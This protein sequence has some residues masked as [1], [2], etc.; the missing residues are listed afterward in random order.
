MSKTYLSIL[1]R[2]PEISL[3]EL[4]AQ[5]SHVQ[6]ITPFAATFTIP[7]APDGDRLAA[8]SA[9]PDINRLGG[10][11]KLAV[12]LEGNLIDHL[13]ALPAGKITIGLSDYS[14]SATA[15]T[16]AGRAMKIKKLLAKK[17]R[18]IR[19]VNNKTAI[20]STATAH[21][22]HLG[23][24]PKH[25]EIIFIK[26]ETYLSL[27]SQNITAYARRDQARPARDAKVGMLPPK[28]AQVLINLAG[29]L[30]PAATV[31][32]PFCG[33]GVIP[34]EAYLLGYTPLGTDKNPRM[35]EYT[36][37]NLAWFASSLARRSNLSTPQFNISTP[38]F[39]IFTADAT[40][41]TWPQ[42]IAAVACETY[43]G[44]PLSNPPSEIVLKQ[45]MQKCQDIIVRFLKNLAPQ[46]AKSTPVVLAIPA[47]LR[48]NGEYARINLDVFANLEYNRTKEAVFNDLLYHRPGQIVARNIII[49]RK[50]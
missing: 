21:H 32:D 3:A 16:V 22:N 35:V 34:Q 49:L 25:L 45:E 1:G 50:K 30:P 44:T 11:L 23:T 19:I 39:N 20:L 18:S 24:K 8:T 46:I 26:G 40:I 36:K 13:A 2:Q 28:L 47:W 17:G 5:F 4:T 6:K 7:T 29:P 9:T 48:P 43:L 37:K 31:L 41:A 10:T 33:T 38:Q 12:K 14:K 42:P 15:R 27:G